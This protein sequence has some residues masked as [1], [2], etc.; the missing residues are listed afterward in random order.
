[1]HYVTIRHNAYGPTELTVT[2]YRATSCHR[3]ASAVGK[4]V[5]ILPPRGAW[6]LTH[7]SRKAMD[8]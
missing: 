2:L 6:E 4:G 3:Y 5:L 1:M 8:D 7:S